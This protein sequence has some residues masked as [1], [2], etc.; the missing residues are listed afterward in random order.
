MGTVLGGRCKRPA[1][2]T[3]AGTSRDGPGDGQ[4][5]GKRPRTHRVSV[6]TLVG[7]RRFR[8]PEA[9]GTGRAGEPDAASRLAPAR[10][11]RTARITSTRGIDIAR[12]PRAARVTDIRV[13]VA[14]I[15]A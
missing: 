8:T 10:C 6:P 7:T 1:R 12:I 9:Q 3:A 2:P 15:A 11:T 5:A 14:R 4:C 13:R